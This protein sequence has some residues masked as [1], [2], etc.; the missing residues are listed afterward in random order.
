MPTPAGKMVAISHT[1]D[2]ALARRAATA[3]A[4]QMGFDADTGHELAL[5]ASEL[6]TNVLTH[7]GGGRL[8]IAALEDGGRRGL[9]LQATDRG[10]GISDVERALTDGFSTAGSMGYGLGSC[11]RMCDELDIGAGPGGVGATV[12]CRRWLRAP[13]LATGP[14]PLD[15]G[16]ATRTHPGSRENG[17]AYAVHH[18]DGGV[19]VAVIDGLGHGQ[20]AHRASMRARQYLDAHCQ[21]PLLDLFRGV[22]Q[23]CR[24]TRGV[25]M[26]AVRF[27]VPLRSF[28]LGSI[29]NV[30]VRY[31]RGP[32]RLGHVFRR[33]ILGVSAPSPAITDH[34]WDPDHV[35]VLFSD[36]LQS[37]W[38]DPAT[39]E[40]PLDLD[41]P[42]QEIAAQLLRRFS[43]D[44]DDVTIAV[45][46][47]RSP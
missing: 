38:R 13:A 39:G 14:M 40:L 41:A 3:L 31:L 45:I 37:H 29:G 7:G 44:S 12:T 6:S 35:L 26:S 42:S 8:A 18:W 20:F 47:E 5:V 25:V 1:S 24:A 34:Q 17:D 19:L 33:G 36:G 4:T 28:A 32:S 23:T 46:K 11:H 30:E 2:V 21:A 43:R 16:V 15:V 27:P 10:P 9:Q 22:G